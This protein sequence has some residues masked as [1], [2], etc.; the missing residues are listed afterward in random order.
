MTQRALASGSLFAST[1]AD[2]QVVAWID[3]QP[4]DGQSVHVA[5]HWLSQIL[6]ERGL[7][8]GAHV[9]VWTHPSDETV[10]LL[11]ACVLC[12]VVTVPLNPALGSREL[13]HIVSDACPALVLSARATQDA[14][15]IQTIDTLGLDPSW[16]NLQESTPSRPPELPKHHDRSALLVLYTSGTTG[17]PKG[18]VLTGRNVMHN[19]DALADAWAL[20]SG[21]RVLHALPL[22][23]V[24]GLCLGL[25]GALR[26]G[27]EFSWLTRFDVS[28]LCSEITRGATVLYAV[29]TMYVRLLD[30]AESDPEVLCALASLRLLVSGSAALA[31][32][33]HRRLARLKITTLRER[34]GLTETLINCVQRVDEP[35]QPGWVGRATAGTEVALCDEHRRP[36]ETQDRETLGELRVRGPNVFAGYLGNTAAT[37]AAMDEMGWFYTGDL[38]MMDLEGRVKIVGRRATDL[39]KT[40]GYKVGAG[41]VES[42]L[43]EHPAIAECAVRGEADEDLGERIVAYAVSRSGSERPTLRA[44]QDLVA[45][46][47]AAHKRPR[48]VHW[49][50]ALP[51]NA[52]GKVLK[53]QL[54]THEEDTVQT[55][56]EIAWFS[57]EITVRFQEIDAAGVMFFARVFEWFHDS[58]FAAMAAH[59]VDFVAVLRD[60]PWLAPIT[61]AEADF[62]R[63]MRF[64]DRLL[65]RLTP[66]VDAQRL[67]IRYEIVQV[68]SP[69]VVHAAG[70]TVH[71]F[72]DAETFRAVAIPEAIRK[73]IG[74]ESAP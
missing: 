44:L 5:T 23:H 19:L 11:I 52:M 54:S 12:G 68:D 63:P 71:A 60:R 28:A 59:G 66:T 43:S 72:V 53:R 7:G 57:Y 9:A 40:G 30:A 67:T 20:T 6:G 58:Y 14:A 1:W 16:R 61:H 31:E 33:E 74:V 36:L 25:Y 42:A 21:D 41:E 15:K 34:Y 62:R 47:L 22:F 18:A 3:G 35:A 27:A 64:G 39:I 2:D 73:A 29:P 70:H 55:T 65:V 10:A 32:R 26:A 69:K 13:E 37:V 50:K 51:R 8:E 56:A 38:A 49:I 17:A 46:L 24:H 4:L 48:E 45:S